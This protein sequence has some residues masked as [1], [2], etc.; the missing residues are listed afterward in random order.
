MKQLKVCTESMRHMEVQ[1]CGCTRSYGHASKMAHTTNEHSQK[2]HSKEQKPIKAFVH[3][4]C[5]RYERRVA[6]I[7]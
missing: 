4:H 1:R 6:H 2:Q 3:W 7:A 5:S